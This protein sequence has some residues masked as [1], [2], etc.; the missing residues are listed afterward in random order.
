[1]NLETLQLFLHLSR[2][3]HFGRTSQECSVSPSALS[4]SIA[5]LEE[6]LGTRLLTRDNRSATLTAASAG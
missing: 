1:M 5:R 2:T 3:L 4:R 6:E